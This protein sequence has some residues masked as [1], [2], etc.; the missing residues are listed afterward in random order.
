MKNDK[1][2]RSEEADEKMQHTRQQKTYMAFKRL[3]QNL[4]QVKHLRIIEKMIS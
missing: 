4:K 2:N 3:K 1:A